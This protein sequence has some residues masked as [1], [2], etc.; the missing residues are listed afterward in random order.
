MIRSK[1]IGKRCLAGFVIAAAL[2]HLAAMIL[3]TSI[4]WPEEARARLPL[5]LLL[6][7]FVPTTAAFFLGRKTWMTTDETSAAYSSAGL[8]ALLV[9]LNLFSPRTVCP[10]R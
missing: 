7:G 4:G 6:L 5:Y 10:L 1:S 3:A 2:G 9:A 8:I